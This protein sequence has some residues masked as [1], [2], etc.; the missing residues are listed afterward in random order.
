MALTEQQ[1]AL[2]EKYQNQQP[3][4]DDSNTGLSDQQKKLLEKYESQQSE[5]EVEDPGFL[6]RTADVGASVL[7]GIPKAL[8]AVTSLGSLVDGLHYVADPIAQGLYDL[9][10]YGDEKL[11]SDFQQNKNAELGQRIKEA[12]ATVDTLPD[13]ASMGDKMYHIYDTMVSQGGEAAEYIGENPSQIFNLIGQTV[14]HIFA[15]GAI[16]KGVKLT[17]KGAGLKPVSALTAGAIGEGAVAGGDAVANIVRQDYDGIGTEYSNDR[18]YGAAAGIGTSLISRGGAKFNKLDIDTA[19]AGGVKDLID[20]VG[21]GSIIKS[22][23]KGLAVEGVEEFLQSGQ[24]QGFT[25]LG[26]D[27]P[28]YE[29]VGSSAVIGGFTGM[30]MGG[31]MSAATQFKSNRAVNNAEAAKEEADYVRELEEDAALEAQAQEDAKVAEAQAEKQAL[32][33]KAERTA[34]GRTRREAASTYTPRDE[35]IKARQA[36]ATE[37][38][39]LDVLNPETEIGQNFETFLDEQEIFDPVDIQKSA[40]TYVKSYQKEND[41]SAQFEAEYVSGLDAHVETVAQA[42]SVVDATPEV[43]QLDDD[44][45]TEASAALDPQVAAVIGQMRQAA[46][47]LDLPD[48]APVAEPAQSE[49][50]S[51]SKKPATKKEQLIEKARE[52]LGETWEQDEPSLSQLAAD[53]RGMYSKG[54]GRK[55]RFETMLGKIAAEKAAALPEV[56]SPLEETVAEPAPAPAPVAGIEG[57]AISYATEKLGNN[58][59]ETN[60]ELVE[61]LAARKYNAFQRTVDDLYNQQP[62]PT[63]TVAEDVPAPVEP[64]VAEAPA[65]QTTDESTQEEPALDAEAVSIPEDL[66]LPKAQK[67]IFDVIRDAINNDE[68]DKVL[69]VN[70]KWNDA[71]IA[72][73]AGVGKG[74]VAKQV[75][76]VL[77]KIAKEN[78]VIGADG[79]GDVAAIQA[80]LRAT[81]VKD[82]EALDLNANEVALEV[83]E[84]GNSMETLASPNQGAYTDVSAEDRAYT[85]SQ[86]ETPIQQ[87]TTDELS[88][89]RAQHDA[90][91]KADSAYNP[92]ARAWGKFESTQKDGN[93][94]FDDMDAGYRFEWLS[95]HTEFQMGDLDEDGLAAYFDQL[96]SEHIQDTK[97]AQNNTETTDSVGQA[98]SQGNQ[99]ASS[100]DGGEVQQTRTEPEVAEPE[101]Q[102]LSAEEQT[103]RAAKVPVVTKKK[104]RVVKPPKN[105]EE[106]PEAKRK[107]KEPELNAVDAVAEK[108]GGEVVYQEGDIALV[109]GYSAITGAPVY[110]AAKGTMFT[111]VDVESYVGNEFTPEQVA[112]LVQA[113]KDAEAEAQRIHDEQPYVTYE[114]GLAFSDNVSPETQ[115][116]IRE[117]KAQLGLGADVYVTT[118]DDARADKLNF[119]GPLRAVGSGTLDAS[120]RGSTRRL[121][122]G[123]HYIIYDEQ[124]SKIA[125]LETIAHEMGH[126][127]Q[128]EVFDQAPPEMQKQLVEEHGKWLREQTTKSAKGLVEALRARK[129]G[130]T[131]SAPDIPFNQV[132]PYWKSF[133]EWY[134]DQVSRWATTQEAPVSAIEKFFSRLGKAMKSFYDKLANK[135]Y[136]PSTTFVEYLGKVKNANL[137]DP[138]ND[139]T[140]YQS[141]TM[142]GSVNPT[143]AS[144]EEHNRK[145]EWVRK[146][147]GPTAKQALD[148]FAEV[149]RGAMQSLKFLHQFVRE[150]KGRMPAAGRMYQAIKE[151]DKTRQDIRRQVEAIAVRAREIKPERLAAVNDFISKS[152]FFQKWGYDPQFTDVDGNVRA[153]KVDP[154]MQQKF[155]RLSPVEQAL[156]RDIFQHGENMRLRK[157]AVA[158][159]L[160]V[161][162]SFFS[163]A[164]LEGPYAPLKRFGGYAGVLKSQAL[165]DAE[166]QDAKDSTEATRKAVEDL[167]SSPSD[168]VVSFFDTMGAA[169]KFTEASKGKFAYAVP[170]E[171]TED[172]MSDRVSNPEV[173]QRVLGAL[174]AADAN[175]IDAASKQAFAEMVRDMYFDSLDERDARVSGAK[176]KNRAGYEKNM[177]RSFLSHARAEAAM[178]S[179]MEHGAEINMA[180]AEAQK[181]TEQDREALS[182]V[183]NMLVAHYKDTLIYQDTLFQRIQ[184]RVA[185]LNSVYMLTSSIGYHVTNATQP[186]MVTVPRLAG[187]F[188]DYSGAWDK[189][190]RGYKVAVGSARLTKKFETEIDLDKVPPK[191]KALLEELQL[192]NLLDVGMEEDLSSFDRFNTGY[193]ALNVASD[194]LGMVTHKLYQAARLVEAHNRISS[195]VAAFDLATAKPQVARRQGMTPAEYAIS[196]V[197]DTQGNFSR[198]DA[199]LIIKKLPKLTTQYRKYQFMMVWAYVNAAKQSFKGESKEMRAMGMRTLAYMTAHAGIF[200]GV[201]GIPLVGTL[202]GLVFLFSGEDEPEDLDR[203][204]QTQVPGKMGEVLSKGVFNFVGIDMSTKLSQGKIFDP[205][206]YLDYDVSEDGVKDLV[207]NLAAGPSGTTAINF[208]R[209]VEYFGQGD[210]LKAIEYMVPK[211][212][213]TAIESYRIGTEGV[214]FK[215]GDVVVDPRDVNI[216][217]LLVNALGL[218]ASEIN[219]IKWTR[220]Q[221]Y[222]LSAYFSEQT[223]RIRREYIDAKRAKD[224]STMSELRDEFRDLQKQKDR[225]RP[226][227]GKDPSALRRQSIMDLYKAPMQQ[228]KREFK[229]KKRFE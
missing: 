72:D 56:T 109:R 108:I 1:Q 203:W 169:K 34:R 131:T 37:A 73:L 158:K 92:A 155:N 191:Y 186:A 88:A 64:V 192:R 151:A 63:E 201:T 221:Q 215:N 140:D 43:L 76:R 185:A 218:P 46:M 120:E 179:T 29:D 107:A 57:Q 84:V 89:V 90:E 30:G 75:G 23:G 62:A 3:V 22:T 121:P 39:E 144:Q 189:L 216:G 112:S 205:F 50:E 167:K 5:V 27:K 81:R 111:N 10:E 85:Q 164:E 132:A 136:L 70:G 2:I 117:W 153:I 47:G 31:A 125:V 173:F 222:E 32:E 166:A 196:V 45:F 217:S 156:V 170:S 139:N 220:S 105:P 213:R 42:K 11:L 157:Q 206:P 135:D 119:T 182:P 149:S 159:L 127:H 199:P 51:K 138:I 150:V 91:M 41:A 28:F 207:F 147:M 40:K 188:G 44:A 14:P 187:D 99:E 49:K 83:Q 130:K 129:T 86:E 61:T 152:T 17:A 214:S 143:P 114:E 133:N 104:R 210:P 227:F 200:A 176:R 36:E 12:A 100:Q 77:E 67:R 80:G 148:D 209:S 178:I 141:D 96:R 124:A 26:N 98:E 6:R 211:G 65:A 9:G 126:V 160:D 228:K 33:E 146:N 69:Q 168:Y 194:K 165:L 95:Y 103:A 223:S 163:A 19:A 102:Q 106:A 38:L 145:G 180:L 116:V 13:D 181:Q 177:V 174:K 204:I 54:G 172:L 123:S 59:R 25:N 53:G 171:R 24:E 202:A 175:Q 128:K 101:A 122:D 82:V 161:P 16:G 195:A 74:T 55:S 78:G 18:L 35:F 154:V 48:L 190:T 60:P 183:Y 71:V 4:Q 79:K 20:E 113:K 229:A 87:Q 110:V 52:L 198:M 68:I 8:G 208:T 197:E 184:D 118:L 94:K 193:E 66:A 21:K 134:A 137:R 212:I 97:D 219:K 162:R 225:V 142:A 226:F 58:W 93:V 224:K 7:T 15:G 115:G